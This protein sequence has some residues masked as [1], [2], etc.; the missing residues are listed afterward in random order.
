MVS[1]L[2]VRLS[3][4]LF[5]IW[6]T[7]DFFVHNETFIERCNLPCKPVGNI[8]SQ[9]VKSLIRQ[10]A[11]LGIWI[12]NCSLLEEVNLLTCSLLEEVNLLTS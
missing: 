4:A 6:P 10:L 1:T 9:S 5:L 7:S 12:D 11:S 8:V 2:L 3:P